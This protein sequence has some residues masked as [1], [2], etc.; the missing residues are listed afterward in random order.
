MESAEKE[1]SQ[2]QMKGIPSAQV[3]ESPEGP[4]ISVQTVGEAHAST[5]PATINNPPSPSFFEVGHL[6]SSYPPPT[7]PSPPF[8]IHYKPKRPVTFLT[9]MENPSPISCLLITILS[10][11]IYSP[12]HLD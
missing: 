10:S 8:Y 3:L 5:P 11:K 7:S 6:F 2:V 9:L 12:S 4:I 1:V